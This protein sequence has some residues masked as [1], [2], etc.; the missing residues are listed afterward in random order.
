LN[1]FNNL[2]FTRFRPIDLGDT[3][4]IPFTQYSGVQLPSADPPTCSYLTRS[5]TTSFC[6]N[7]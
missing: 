6:M 5:T 7:D 1:L 4:A 2:Y 3:V